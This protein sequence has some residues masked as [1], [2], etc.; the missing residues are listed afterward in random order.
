MGFRKIETDRW[1]FACEGFVKG[2]KHL[3]K[4]ITRKKSQQ[5]PVQQRSLEQKAKDVSVLEA[6]KNDWLRKE[7]ESLQIDKNTLMQELVKL[8]QHQETS[9]GE[10]LSLRGK[11]QGMEEN[12]QQMLSFIVMAMQN[13]G[14]FVQLIQPKESNWRRP[15]SGRKILKRVTEDRELVPSDRMIVPYQPSVDKSPGSTCIPS[16]NSE[17][18][19]ELDD[20]S[21][22]LIDAGDVELMSGPMD[23]RSVPSDG[24]IVRYQPLA[25]ESPEP[26]SNSE[27]LLE[28]SF[29]SDEL[30]DLFNIDFMSGSMNE[31]KAS[32]E[33]GDPL[34]LT[35][36][37]DA[38][39]MLDKLLSSPLTY[40]D[41]DYMLDTENFT[42][43]M[44]M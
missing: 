11:L 18:S 6:S 31:E 3:L 24:A 42:D 5:V 33:H 22:T 40:K 9:Q 21:D 10:L 41:D 28:L 25:D 1:E 20:S 2:Q 36:L 16:S 35:D 15:E 30:K 27:K 4:N 37:S 17:K 8:R 38:D 29:S 43:V 19:I 44:E 26:T 32:S 14:F 7:V 34:V 23:K 39:G 12:Q 13:P